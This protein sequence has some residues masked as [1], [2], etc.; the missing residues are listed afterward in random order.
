MP[1]AQVTRARAVRT[2]VPEPVVAVALLEVGDVALGVGQRLVDARRGDQ[3]Q[4][5]EVVA[6]QALGIVHSQVGHQ[7]HAV[8]LE[9]SVADRAVV[10]G[11]VEHQRPQQERPVR[12]DPRRPVAADERQE[13]LALRARR[14]WRAPCRRPQAT[15]P[16]HAVQALA[17]VLPGGGVSASETVQRVL[18]F[19]TAS[20]RWPRPRRSAARCRC[21]RRSTGRCAR[22]TVSSGTLAGAG[23]STAPRAMSSRRNTRIGELPCRPLAGCPAHAFAVEEPLH[24]RQERHEL[25]VVAL[26]ELAGSPVNSSATSCQGITRARPRAAPSAAGSGYLPRE[27]ASAAAAR[28]RSVGTGVRVSRL[29]VAA[30]SR[31]PGALSANDRRS[32]RFPLHCVAAIAS[33]QCRRA[34]GLA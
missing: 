34:V 13:L 23:T 31:L 16:V 5:H 6:R 26:L 11:V 22:S 14:R 7:W 18:R 24:V 2:L 15:R 30:W 1:A 25:V 10:I 21:R 32:T 12:R 3:S 8:V 4:A 17:V 19:E 20:G 9:Q 28:A 27:S 29:W 33:A